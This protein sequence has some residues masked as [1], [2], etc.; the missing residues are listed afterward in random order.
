[1]EQT[2]K[3]SRERI[4]V[5]QAE[6]QDLVVEL[7]AKR[8]RKK[9]IDTEIARLRADIKRSKG[10]KVESANSQGEQSSDQEAT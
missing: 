5:L 3:E 7:R 9:E 1:M 2:I 4:K 10:N 8:A 6:K